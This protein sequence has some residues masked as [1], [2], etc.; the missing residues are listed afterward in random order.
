MKSE[1]VDCVTGMTMTMTMA[2]S[3][4]S[5]Q[6]SGRHMWEKTQRTW[7][8]SRSLPP[9]PWMESPS[10]PAVA[11]ETQR[12]KEKLNDSVKIVGILHLTPTSWWNLS[13]NPEPAGSFRKRRQLTIELTVIFLTF[14]HC[15]VDKIK[16]SRRFR[17]QWHSV[18]CQTCQRKAENLLI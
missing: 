2:A 18:Y 10:A 12:Q 3:S 9:P 7:W 4:S 16:S 15:L 14:I 6:A 17:T 11:L 13:N 8:E 5:S 1:T